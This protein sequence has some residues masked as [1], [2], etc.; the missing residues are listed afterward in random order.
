[1]LQEAAFRASP[2]ELPAPPPPS[3]KRE[4]VCPRPL[5]WCPLIAVYR[6]CVGCVTTAPP[7]LFPQRGGN[8]ATEPAVL[9]CFRPSERWLLP[10]R[11]L[12]TPWCTAIVPSTAP[13]WVIAGPPAV[14][15]RSAPTSAARWRM[16][17]RKEDTCPA[18]GK[19]VA[20]GIGT[21]ST[22]ISSSAAE[23]ASAVARA[24][25]GGAH[26]HMHRSKSL[27]HALRCS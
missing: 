16:C 26:S 4:L 6:R 5:G 10:R 18:L 15:A 1:M 17:R 13:S 9:R 22:P 11:L 7:S 25:G 2:T 23:A 3:A 27:R 21:V 14:A 24:V 8:A 19:A 20:A 12:P